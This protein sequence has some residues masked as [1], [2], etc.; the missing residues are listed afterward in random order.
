MPLSEPVN[1]VPEDTL[2][3][4]LSP[5]WR[6]RFERGIVFMLA[7]LVDIPFPSWGRVAAECAVSPFHFHRM[8]RAIFKETPGRYVLRARLQL[9]VHYLLESADKSVTD[10][11][12]SC[13]FSSSQSLARALKRETGESPKNIR[14]LRSSYD[15]GT[16]EALFQTLGHPG[17]NNSR[18]IEAQLARNIVFTVQ[19]RPAL[20][21]K[22]QTVLPPLEQ[23]VEKAYLKYD[24]HMQSELCIVAAATEYNKPFTEMTMSAGVQTADKQLADIIFPAGTFLC[25]RIR[26]ST[27]SAY[28]AALDA[29][30]SHILKEGL[31]LDEE[32]YGF[33]ILHNPAEF[34]IQ[35]SDMTLGVQV[36]A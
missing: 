27:D 1:I 15:T 6:E 7:H 3:A 33:E 26:L 25:C 17:E 20:Y 28:I 9:A 5:L 12:L 36:K 4:S 24:R 32:G 22:G 13:G 23:G 35:P 34:Y 29:I 2:I 31:E 30:Y 10:V 16:I 19:Q 21:L 11:A 8:F 14:A 18:S